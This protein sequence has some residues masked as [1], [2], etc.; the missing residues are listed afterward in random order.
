MFDGIIPPVAA[1]RSFHASRY[2]KVQSRYFP[3]PVNA[4]AFVVSSVAAKFKK[5]S[6]TESRYSSQCASMRGYHCSRSRSLVVRAGLCSRW[7][8][9]G[10]GSPT[11]SYT[12]ARRSIGPKL[13]FQMLLMIFRCGS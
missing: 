7:N 1:A 6:P 9:P 12:V 4:Y 2:S 11:Q 13:P 10:T 8:L 3:L 5:L